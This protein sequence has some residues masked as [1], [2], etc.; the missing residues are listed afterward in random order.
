[1][2]YPIPGGK[3]LFDIQSWSQIWHWLWS[4][5]RLSKKPF[6]QAGLSLGISYL[7]KF[8]FF[9]HDFIIFY[10]FLPLIIFHSLCK[11]VIRY[12]FYFVYHTIK[13]PLDIYFYLAP[14]VEFV[15]PFLNPNIRKYR[16]DYGNSPGTLGTSLTN[17][18]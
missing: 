7:G 2:I 5:E 10:C 16:F 11:T 15:H 6:S 4:I 13:Q 1:M 12:F 18:T 14:K 9:S 3:W 17:W 8:T